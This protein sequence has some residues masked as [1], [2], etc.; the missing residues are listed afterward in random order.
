MGITKIK[1]VYKADVT[2]QGLWLQHLFGARLDKKTLRGLW[3]DQGLL[4]WGGCED[5]LSLLVL[6]WNVIPVQVPCQSEENLHYYH[7]SVT[8]ISLNLGRVEFSH[9][10]RWGLHPSRCPGLVWAELLLLTH[11]IPTGSLKSSWFSL[12]FFKT[13]PYSNSAFSLKDLSKWKKKKKQ[14][15][16]LTN[17]DLGC[18]KFHTGIYFKFLSK[19]PH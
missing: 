10:H 16:I 3:Q 18:W 1:D 11:P 14:T 12:A 17:V 8:E 4:L 7:P 13:K 6:L 9:W 5:V 15:Q 2:P 19:K